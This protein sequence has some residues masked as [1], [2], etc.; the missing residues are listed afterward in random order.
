MMMWLCV[1]EGWWS[2]TTTAFIHF[3]SFSF[4]FHCTAAC[5]S[6]FHLFSTLLGNAEGDLPS[7]L[8][9]LILNKSF[10]FSKIPTCICPTCSHSATWSFWYCSGLC[11]TTN[12]G[13]CTSTW[14]S[15][16][17]LWYWMSTFTP[18]FSSYIA[19]W[20]G[21]YTSDMSFCRRYDGWTQRDGFDDKI[22]INED[23]RS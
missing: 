22:K 8:K 21:T 15:I 12:T 9:T 14:S 7:M 19:K 6:F 23:Y 1:S 17:P 18:V 2:A 16:A 13:R 10:N 3:P 20:I 4:Y 11:C 5:G